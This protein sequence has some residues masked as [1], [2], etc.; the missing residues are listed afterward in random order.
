MASAPRLAEP[1]V[2]LWIVHANTS[3]YVN[4]VPQTCAQ[5]IALCSQLLRA[6]L[7]QRLLCAAGPPFV[8]TYQGH[9]VRTRQTKLPLFS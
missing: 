7:H 6:D 3:W 8:V 9:I 2:Q 5:F 1:M 4:P